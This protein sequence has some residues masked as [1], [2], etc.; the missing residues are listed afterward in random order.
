MGSAIERGAR[1]ETAVHRSL[2]D[3]L[4]GLPNRELFADRLAL[5]LARARRGG[6]PPAVLIADLDQFKLINDSLG[7]QA[8]DELLRAVAPRLASAVRDTDTV[9]RFGGDEFVVLCD[10]VGSERRRSSSPSGS[11]RCSTSR[12]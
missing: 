6:P 11:P 12:S 2:H 8:G 4:T 9:A 10:G 7:H 1:E 5:T 3:P